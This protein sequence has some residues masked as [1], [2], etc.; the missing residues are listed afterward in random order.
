MKM[1]VRRHKLGYV[2]GATL[3]FI[4]LTIFLIVLWKAWPKLSSEADPMSAFWAFLWE[5]Q[6]ILTHDIEFKL[7]YFVI[8]AVATLIS[9]IAVLMFSRQK[10]FL[11]G[12]TMKL[13]CPFCKKKWRAGYPRGQVTC[14]HCR[15]S[16][17]P[18]MIEE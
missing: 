14:P 17:H 6:L 12:K 8:L 1:T 7:A 10:F 2:L 9:G 3:C 4:G 13:Q 16:V 15:H 11:P 18:R 5:E